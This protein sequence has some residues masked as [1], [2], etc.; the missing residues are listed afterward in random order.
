MNFRHK[1]DNL[2]GKHKTLSKNWNPT[3]YVSFLFTEIYKILENLL[4]VTGT[5]PSFYV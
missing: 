4:A 5:R 3:T 2:L 1:E